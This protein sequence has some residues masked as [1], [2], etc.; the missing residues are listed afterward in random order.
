MDLS[1]EKNHQLG[2]KSSSVVPLNFENLR[3]Q[4]NHPKVPAVAAS[5]NQPK[6]SVPMELNTQHDSQL[7]EGG[8]NNVVNAI[9]EPVIWARLI[10][11]SPEPI[12]YELTNIEPDADERHNLILLGRGAQ[13]HI[14]FDNCPR[15]SNRHCM[16]Y[17]KMNVSNPHQHFLEAYIEDMSANGTFLNKSTRLSKN[18]P[19]LLRT[20][21]ELYLVN[22]ELT[23]L[24]GSNVTA[25][26][27]ISNAFTVILDLP[28]PNLGG[29]MASSLRSQTISSALSQELGRSSTVIRLLNQQRNIHDFYELRDILGTGAAGKVYRGIKKDT[30]QE[31]A[32]KMID[33]RALGGQEDP[34]SI[35]KEAE[36]LRSIRHPNIIHFE[37]IFADELA[38]SIYLVM[39]ISNGGDLFDRIS[40]KKFYSESDAK[41][42]M[43]QLLEAM[44][45]LHERKVA[46]RDLKPENILL[47]H[48][49]N[50]TYVKITDFGLAKKIDDKGTKTYC[51]TPQYFAPEVMERKFSTRGAG[52]YSVA[53]DMWSMGCILYVLL[54]GAFP[55]NAN[56][57]RALLAAMRS[58]KYNTKHPRWSAISNDAKDLLNQLLNP[59]PMH[60]LTAIG[61][62]Q[63]HWIGG[64]GNTSQMS[65]MMSIGLPTTLS[66]P[67]PFPPSLDMDKEKKEAVDNLLMPPPKPVVKRNTKG[68][69]KKGA[70]TAAS[71]SPMTQQTTSTSPGQNG[72]SSSNSNSAID[73]D[74]SIRVSLIGKRKRGAAQETSNSSE[75]NEDN[76]TSTSTTSGR[77]KRSAI[78]YK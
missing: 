66:P 51:G 58:V 76:T 52:T 1:P 53:A 38:Y 13:C 43:K 17:C 49:D 6:M 2:R 26:D 28:R 3:L 7:E 23:E 47:P 75:D 57:D 14:R 45:F 55:F 67:P 4:S 25:M 40:R 22:P 46:H 71:T 32:I 21:D 36:M 35:T 69:N 62:L 42:V 29:G 8:N 9:S 64:G 78:S 27:I 59:D 30:G 11:K 61:A 24:S 72:G 34:S 10:T 33:L 74:S 50:D 12:T 70:A 16:I 19:R 65:T 60:R 48:I 41:L 63:H 5:S 31:W 39:E 20:G 18:V 68:G 37:D 15:I 54:V 73:A 77:S 44:A 56:S